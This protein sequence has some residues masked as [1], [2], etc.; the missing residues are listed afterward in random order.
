VEATILVQAAA[1]V[2]ETNYMLR[3][4][5]KT[6]VIKGVV[7]WV[8]FED[9]EAPQTLNRLSQTPYFKGVRPMLQDISDTNWILRPTHVPI[10]AALIENDLVFDA[11]IQ[12]RHMTAILEVL[13]RHKELRCVINHGAKPNITGGDFTDWAENI[14]KLAEQT[15]AFCKVSGL[16]TEAGPAWTVDDIRPYVAHLLKA[17]GPQRLIWGSDW[18]V[19]NLAGSFDAWVECCSALFSG[20]PQEEQA[21]ICHGNAQRVYRIQD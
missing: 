13:K 3:L 2:A 4:A 14:S 10:F 17:F 16:I 19:C 20:L 11:L 15:S 7:G 18:P 6:D 8:N 12:P 9:R 5:D 1:T 21:M